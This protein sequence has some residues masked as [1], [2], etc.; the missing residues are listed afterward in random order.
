MA[1]YV[2]D[3]SVCINSHIFFGICNDCVWRFLWTLSTKSELN[4]LEKLVNISS[5]RVFDSISLCLFHPMILYSSLGILLFLLKMW[6]VWN[7]KNCS[8]HF[9][10]DASNSTSSY[11]HWNYSIITLYVNYSDLVKFNIK[12]VIAFY[13]TYNL[14]TKP[15]KYFYSLERAFHSMLRSLIAETNAMFTST[16]R[17]NAIVICYTLIDWLISLLVHRIVYVFWHLLITQHVTI[18][19]CFN[20]YVNNTDKNNR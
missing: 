8:W 19:L 15:S 18:D 7:H 6:D 5:W 1:W 11:F 10:A 2:M 16:K 14:F 9:L 13:Y 4:N 20:T 3:I 17:R 12:L